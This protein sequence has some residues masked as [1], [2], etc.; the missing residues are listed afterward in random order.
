MSADVSVLPTQ[1]QPLSNEEYRAICRNFESH[2]PL[3]YVMW[4]IGRPVFNPNCKTARVIFDRKGNFLKFEFNPLFW[5]SMTPYERSF[6]IAH[7]ANHVLS[8]HGARGAMH[9][10][11]DRSNIAADILVNHGLINDYG[12]IRSE[13][14]FADKLCWLDTVYGDKM[15]KKVGNERSFEWHYM[16]LGSLSK[17]TPLKVS[18]LQGGSQ[19]SGQGGTQGQPQPGEGEPQ[20]GEADPEQ[21]EGQPQK[22]QGL[23][24]GITPQI[25]TVDDHEQSDDLNPD[26]LNEVFKQIAEKSKNLSEE[27]RNQIAD[28]IESMVK[29]N[30][31]EGDG[32]GEGDQELEVGK[33]A[34][35]IIRQIRHPY[36]PKPKFESIIKKWTRL[37]KKERL[38]DQFVDRARRYATLPDDLML[39]TQKE[40]RNYGKHKIKVWLFLDTSGSCAGYS[41]RFFRS[42]QGL[43]R[44]RFDIRLFCF[45]TKVYEVDLSSDTAK[46]RGYG[47]TNFGIIENEIQLIMRREGLK[48]PEA[49]FLLTDG[50]G[51]KVNPERPERWQWLMVDHSTQRYVPSKSKVHKLKDFE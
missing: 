12:F 26:D 14:S 21:G 6:V 2:H 28:A 15:A 45:D 36:K 38:K 49:V 34:G 31:K 44:D 29:S 41:E 48:Y 8:N 25:S 24:D 17:N 13:I 51:T 5:A 22:G 9:H 35:D 40:V 7:E 39:P 47:G 4:E 43:D 11:R 27:E 20:P 42:V 1:I 32:S 3:F 18:P 23:G 30:Q 37:A 33:G 50:A 19:G 46:L 10:D 16:A